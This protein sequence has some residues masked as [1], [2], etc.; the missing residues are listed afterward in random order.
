MTEKTGE[1]ELSRCQFIAELVIAQKNRGAFLSYHD[2]L[3]IEKWLKLCPDF[4][5]LLL[6]LSDLL[7]SLFDKNPN[8][9][10]QAIDRTVMT[11]I[12][13]HALRS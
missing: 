11:K 8:S 3:V 2:Y 10:L 5:F 9:S 13:R 1:D 7:P 6:L 12:A 4:D